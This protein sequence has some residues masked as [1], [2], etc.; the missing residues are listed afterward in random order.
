MKHADHEKLNSPI[1]APR[2]QA[3]RD[4]QAKGNLRKGGGPM[5]KQAKSHAKEAEKAELASYKLNKKS[6][7]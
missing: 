3:D 5:A 4:K 6:K 7:F 1:N 2:M